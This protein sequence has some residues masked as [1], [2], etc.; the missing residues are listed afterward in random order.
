MSETGHLLPLEQTLP[1]EV[2]PP[3]SRRERR[4]QEVRGRITE[5]A[6]GLF[7]EQGCELTTVE[8]ICDI[9]DVA[10]KTFYNYFAS[11]L[12]L[13][14]EL[15]DSLL[16]GETENLLELSMEK[17]A[18]VPEQLAFFFDA[19]AV[20]ME[21]FERLERVLIN[22]TMADLSMD[23]G[24]SGQ[25]LAMLNQAFARIFVE[26]RRRGELGAVYSPEFLA[27]IAVGAMN[28]IILNWLH[29]E[30]YP[31]TQRARELGQYLGRGLS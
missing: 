26:G 27:E 4:K 31:I 21:K 1:P 28:A 12:H 17:C 11:K 5:A 15:S 3:L 9:A 20:N 8:D 24:T 10:R 25:Q 29:D 16:F 14:K 6:I 23:D 7:T 22:Q 18:T 30:H 19:M 13:I 2:Q